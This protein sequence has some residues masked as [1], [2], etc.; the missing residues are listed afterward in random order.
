MA[1]ATLESLWRCFEGIVPATIAT[2]SKSGIPNVSMISHVHYVDGRHVALSRQFFNKTTRNLDENP[3]A[4]LTLWDP[5][6]M[7]NHRMR[8]RFLRSETRG[9]LFEAMAERIQVI[10]SHCGMK[11]V[12]RLLSADVFEVLELEN[13]PCII[14]PLPDGQA[15]EPPPEPVG[16][17]REER[18]E[19][20]ALQRMLA[21]VR[22]A[23][24]LESLLDTFLEGL[25]RDLGFEHCIVLVP[26][27]SGRRLVTLAS[28]G[29]GENGVGAEVEIG[30][31]LIGL[32]A[33]KRKALRLGP[34]D[35]A[36]RY[37]RAVRNRA[38]AA[39]DVPF[40]REIPLPGLPTAQSQIA[41]PLVHEGCLVGVLAAE[42]ER[43]HAFEAWHEVFL[44]VLA[45]QFAQGIAR[46]LE[47][48]G[49][50]A[51]VIEPAPSQRRSE[52]SPLTL[53]ASATPGT[54]QVSPGRTH[55]FC[56]YR[57]DDCIF[58]DGDYLVRGVPARIL[59]R[60]L[61]GHQRDGQAL[62][63]NREL[64]LDPSLGLPALRDNLESRLILLRRRLEVRCPDV[65][66]VP[67]ARGE[68]ALAIQG[69]Y[70]LVERASAALSDGV[71]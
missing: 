55:S 11:G 3:L 60:V 26:D 31:G 64:R 41:L 46:H 58:V 28:R 40:H 54:S 21:I 14:E 27:E 62:F 34:L 10:A 59:W 6:T 63:K 13:P 71:S 52:P 49:A 19:L 68:F 53:E 25:A 4:L 23:S 36:L 35:S 9:A 48:D 29:Y 5:I 69:S 43:S 18:S 51:P 2:C 20:W 22:S 1:Q 38:R 61:S 15:D 42:S 12:F 16:L 33:E 57:N 32:V 17:P 30:E 65:R 67:R 66:L 45:D 7:G 8:V 37:G 24:D 56:L 47:A 70:E 39:G 50:E 44:G